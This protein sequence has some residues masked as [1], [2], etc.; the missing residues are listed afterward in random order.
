[1]KNTTTKLATLAFATL[2][3]G[4]VLADHNSPMGE[5]WANMPNDIHNTRIE[6]KG[7]NETFREFVKQGAGADSVNRYADADIS[8]QSKAGN[9]ARGNAK[10]SAA[11]EQKGSRETKAGGA[12]QQQ[13]DRSRMREL[14]GRSRAA[15]PG[16]RS[17]P[18]GGA[19][20]R[21]RH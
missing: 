16:S 8:G 1:M 2:A 7:D 15:G 19:G 3:A 4:T 10:D 6:T 11:A 20:R 13:R 5:G 9:K 17:R 18:M 21:G 12:A 14:E